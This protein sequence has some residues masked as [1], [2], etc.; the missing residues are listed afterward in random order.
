MPEGPQ[1]VVIKEEV[2]HFIGQRLLSAEGNAQEI[3]F[4]RIKGNELI[5]VKTFGKELLFCFKDFTIRIHLMLFGKYAIDSKLN[6][7]LRLGFVF[8]GGYIN[9]YACEC[10]FIEVPL[11]GVYDW[12]I[13]VMNKK[14]N[15][16]VAVEKL[17]NKPKQIICEALLDQNILAGVGNKL[18]NESLFRRQVHPE[19]IVGEIPKNVLKGLVDECVKLSFEYLEAKHVGSDN[20]LWQVYKRKECVRDHIPIRKE[21]IGKSGRTC[22]YCDKCQ[23]LYLSDEQL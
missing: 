7:V 6:R 5:D 18:K 12:T 13:D 19:S 10:R 8:E 17:L 3:P 20:E 2:E 21:K 22:Y 9:F 14:F 15:G 23:K 1:M 4:E 11:D 16:A